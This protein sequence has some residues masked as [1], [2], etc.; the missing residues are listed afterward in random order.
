M[1]EKKLK[2]YIYLLLLYRAL[3]IQEEVGGLMKFMKSVS[4]MNVTPETGRFEASCLISVPIQGLRPLV[5]KKM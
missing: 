5:L 1:C 2:C 3:N 4:W